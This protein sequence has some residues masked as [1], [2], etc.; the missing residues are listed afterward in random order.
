[1]ESHVKIR[2]NVWC[3][4]IDQVHI[5]PDNGRPN[6]LK[7]SYLLNSIAANDINAFIGFILK[8]LSCLDEII[9]INVILIS[10]VFNHAHLIK[11]KYVTSSAQ[12]LLV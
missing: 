11:F 12:L 8:L 6:E 5:Q 4:I 7:K 10:N 3:G 1:M 9:L 2:K